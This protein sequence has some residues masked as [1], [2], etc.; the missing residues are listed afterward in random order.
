MESEK[1]LAQLMLDVSRD[2]LMP[3]VS[4]H[5]RFGK[6]NYRVGS[7]FAT[8]VKSQYPKNSDIINFTLTFG[9]KTLKNKRFKANIPLY[10]SYSENP[11]Q[12]YFPDPTYQDCIV[13]VV[14]HEFAH[15]MQDLESRKS[16]KGVHNRRFY[17][18][19][20]RLYEMGMHKKVSEYLLAHEEFQ[21]AEYE[22]D[23][24]SKVYERIDLIGERYVCVR[25][26]KSE[27]D[28][29][30]VKVFGKLNPKRFSFELPSGDK[31][32]GYY[33]IVARIA[34]K[35]EFESA[36]EQ[37]IAM[38]GELKE[39]QISNGLEGSKYSQANLKTKTYIYF[40]HEGKVVKGK[41]SRLNKNTASCTIGTHT[42]G[43]VPYELIER[44]E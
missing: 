43:R 9:I 29:E 5:H 39:N 32:I 36:R 24:L 12:K 35:S 25:G 44:A 1:K 2:I 19:L 15:I 33:P 41:I 7:G 16:D 4:D 37:Y 14:M 34:D 17:S 18:C 20:N 11:R 31:M 8:Q 23:E 27:N 28:Y 42:K 40:T 26:R 30:I 6:I 21:R 13:I 3:L 22:S 10:I 38:H